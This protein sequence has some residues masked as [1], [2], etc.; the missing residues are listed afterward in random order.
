MT[1]QDKRNRLLSW[2][3]AFWNGSDREVQRRALVEPLER[4]ELFAVDPF[5]DMLNAANSNSNNL[6][7]GNTQYVSES[8]L[9]GEGEAAPDLV[10]FAK[11]LAAANV[12]FFGAAWCPHCNA[13]KQ[14]FQDGGKFL[15]FVEVTNPDRTR[16]ATGIAE[17]I[18]EYPT[19]KFP[20]GSKLS[21]EL[22]LQTIS[23]R[24]GVAI[25]T[26]S[27]PSV[28]DI[29]NATVSIGSPLYVPVDAYDPN[30]NPLTITVTS[31]NPSVVAASMQTGNRSLNI[32]TDF[33][34]MVF[35]LFEDMAPR[36]SQRVIQLAQSGFYDGLTFHRVQI[37]DLIQGGDPNG[38]GTGGSQLGNFDDQ[39]HVDLQHN[40][41]GVLSYAKS[42]DD[43]NDSQFFITAQARRDLDY[44]HSVFGQL[45]EGD[46]VRDAITKTATNGSSPLNPVVINSALVFT[47]T[48]NGLIKLKATGGTGTANITVTVTD[49]EGNS[50]SKVFQVTVVAD[51]F[52]SGPFL[53]DVAT[54][55]TSAGVPV[56]VN[57]TSQDVEG[58]ARVYSVQK[59][60]TANYTVEVNSTTGVATVTPGAGFTGELQFKA[61]VSQATGVTNNTGSKTDE[62]LIKVVVGPSIPTAVD[63]NAASDSGTLDS[64]NITNSSSLSFTV[65][66]TTS[67]ATIKLKAGGNVIGQATASGTSTVVTVSNPS[68]LGQGPIVIVATQTVG[69]DESGESPGLTIN[70]DTTAPVTLASSV[71]PSNV[72]FA[73]ALNLNLNHAEEGQG[74]IYGLTSAPTGMTINSSNG[75]ISWTPAADQVG[76]RTFTLVLTDAAGN[77]TNQQVSIT[78]LEQPLV[79]AT[80]QV[81]DL[82]GSPIT[83]IAQGQN[84]KVQ[85][86][87]Q[88]LR[89]SDA[90]KGVF[91]A[92]VDLLFDS[93]IIE[94]IATN[95]ISHGT[96]YTT[97]PT[98]DVLT[99]GVI[100]ELGGLTKDVFTNLDGDPRLL[101][102]VTFRAKA[103]GNPTLRLDPPDLS[104]SDIL[105]FE[106]SAN[107]EVPVSKVSFGTSSFAV[108][109]NFQLANDSFNF[110]EDV[111]SRPLNV[112]INDTVTGGAVLTITAVGTTSNGGTV[113]IA[114]DGKSLNYTSANNFNGAESFT[115]TARNQ[116]GVTQT[117]TVTIQVTDVNDPPVAI[118]DTFNAFVGSSQNVIDVLANDTRGV[119]AN[120]TETL[121][122]SAVGTGSQGGTIQIGSSGLNIRYTPKAGFAGT[123]TFTY[124][125][126][127]GRGG[128]AT[129]TV[130]VTV[131][132]QNP[133]PTA[134]S[135]SFN[136][137]E[138]AAQASFDVLAN[139]STSDVGETLTIGG[140]A[141]STNGAQVSVS[142][143]S[144]N[145]LYR[146]AANFAGTDVIVYTLR[147]SRGATA[148]GT[149]TFTVTAVNDPPNA[150]DDTLEV[151]TAVATTTLFVL[152]NDTNVDAGE[153]LTITAVTQPASGKGT[154][155]ISSDGKTIIYTSPATT[156]E[157]NF[158][159]TYTLGDG[160]G[161]TDTASVTVTAKAFVPRKIGGELEVMAGGMNIGG[162]AVRLQGSDYN[163]QTV[164]AQDSITPAGTFAFTNLAPGDY[165]LLREPLPFLHDTGSEVQVASPTNSGD[166][167]NT[168]LVVGGLRPQFFDIRDF[169]GNRPASSLTV[170]VDSSGQQKW[171]SAQGEWANLKSLNV[172]TNST[173][174][175]VVNATNASSQTLTGNVP[176]TNPARVIQVGQENSMRLLRILG[177]P[178]EVGLTTSTGRQPGPSDANAP[179]TFTTTSTG[180]KH[181]ILRQGTGAQPTLASSITVDYRGSLVS[182]GNVFDETYD[183]PSPATF[184][185]SGLIQ[186]WQEG[187]QLLKAGGKIELEIPPGLGYGASGS[188][189]SIPPNAT[190]NFIIELISV[191]SNPAQTGSGEGEGESSL[192][193]LNTSARDAIFG[194]L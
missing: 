132:Q 87:V 119:D 189:S 173:G 165:R 76:N 125:L 178:S 143:D 20:D 48:E 77:V 78:V 172:S 127:D 14:L 72:Q 65:T 185:L 46:A 45:V 174:A 105:L 19:W 157:G 57:L 83:T 117:A 64:D 140:I 121:T 22:T 168:Q 80:L 95:P 116:D 40:Q 126:S 37:N 163:G 188:G 179:T 155:A 4:R 112:L 154:V 81:V 147:D 92:F 194:A 67:G 71:F 180:L 141:S 170:A 43:T 3:N 159:F 10:A 162:V 118:N 104:I 63:L 182:N 115:Y 160:N 93:N 59:V 191:N 135:D 28:A 161:Q 49:T 97:A 62:Q 100:N 26:A 186:G 24:S 113:T 82:N 149:V 110:D 84:F 144:K 74:L 36:P 120:S 29:A 131:A 175:L 90:A 60:G 152:A 193:P 122:V 156:F 158:S 7:L 34:D 30:G 133:P 101:A 124:T 145:L 114:A 9:V 68:S 16:N 192:D 109:S 187:L 184:N 106:N 23:Q 91:S 44:N 51:Q 5:A 79:G 35:Q 89:A 164:A 31:S 107:G 75:V 54:V 32:R 52:N 150:V 183:G 177:A 6:G 169:L 176:T 55:R 2:L 69:T 171:Y 85:V 142:S 47:D 88:D 130:S 94:P 102:E 73:Q 103:A 108:G 21:G 151:Q 38:N 86:F 1:R 70:R 111:G 153:T 11:A 39:Y 137:T 166:N 138:D 18:T 12:T 17:N 66:G 56:N 98:G 99:A 123:E 33:G 41:K 15:P 61:I 25:P 134:V 13:Q 27:A 167:L 146:P 96:Q 181:K 129:A 148:P 58:D 128:T 53:N 42:S 139:D 8:E 50:T 190:L 136:V